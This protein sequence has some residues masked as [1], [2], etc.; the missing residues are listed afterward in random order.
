MGAAAA[1]GGS[2]GPETVRAGDT[3]GALTPEPRL[4]LAAFGPSNLKVS[5]WP[6]AH[7]PI[8]DI[9]YHVSAGDGSV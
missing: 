4:I 6:P 9:D 8:L 5:A 1:G 7:F 2:E 3:T